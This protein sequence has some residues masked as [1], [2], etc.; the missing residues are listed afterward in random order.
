MTTSSSDIQ[1][2]GT[3][4]I[5]YDPVGTTYTLAELARR[6]AKQSDNTAAYM[7]TKRLGQ[8]AIQDR[9][10]AW[11]MTNTSV[12]DDTTT[13]ADVGTL[14]VKLGKRQLLPPSQTVAVLGL[15]TDTDFEDRLPALLPNYAIIAH[16]IGT[17]SN[18]VINDAGLVITP[19]RSYAIAIMTTGTDV[20]QAIH[21]E[22]QVSLDVYN[23]ELTLP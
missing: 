23:F 14:F 3:G 10:A 5:R 4:S 8:Q 13:P 9:I 17:E 1:N 12:A 2:F 7:L 18:G 16:K 21:A 22:Q 15:L 6:M 20:D 11:G 19:T